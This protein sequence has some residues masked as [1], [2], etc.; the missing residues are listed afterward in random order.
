MNQKKDMWIEVP[1]FLSLI[2]L[3]LGIWLTEYRWRF[4]F[5]SILLLMIAIV[6]SQTKT[7]LN[8]K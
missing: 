4:I 1:G 7:Y 6:N 3:F 2:S 5:S 8:K